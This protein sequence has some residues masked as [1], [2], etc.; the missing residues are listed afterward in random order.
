MKQVSVLG[1]HAGSHGVEI[2][3]SE[4]SFTRMARW[5]PTVP[6]LHT[7]VRVNVGSGTLEGTFK[8]LLSSL[9]QMLHYTD[10]EISTLSLLPCSNR[11]RARVACHSCTAIG[12]LAQDILNA[13]LFK[14]LKIVST[15]P[16]SHEDITPA[17]NYTSCKWPS[18]WD[19]ANLQIYDSSNSES[20]AVKVKPNKVSFYA[21]FANE[22]KPVHNLAMPNWVFNSSP[23]FHVFNDIL[24]IFCCW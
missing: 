23:A 5:G 17:G 8:C 11:R 2:A 3:I 18:A 4:K 16:L 20:H 7:P 24:H 12:D 21:L 19:G 10:K 14:S 6:F 9:L 1:S 15:F 22:A 13:H